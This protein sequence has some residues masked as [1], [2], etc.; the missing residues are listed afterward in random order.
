MKYVLGFAC[1][2]D[3]QWLLIKK[4]RPEWQSGL[5][6]GI[7]GKIEENEKP[8]NAMNRECFEEVKLI[9]DWKEVGR[10]HGPDWE[11]YIYFAQD[12]VVSLYEQVED[13]E[14]GLY[15]DEEWKAL[16]HISNLEYL[17]PFCCMSNAYIILEYGLEE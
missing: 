12:N 3:G 17:I 6:N 9:L 4:N 2:E 5:L 1:N 14:L 10:M 11:C 13:E 15:T 7:G 8:I 16:P